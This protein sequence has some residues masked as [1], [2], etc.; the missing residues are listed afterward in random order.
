MLEE[1][2]IGFMVAGGIG[3]SGMQYKLYKDIVYERAQIRTLMSSHDARLASIESDLM[4]IKANMVGW[5]VLKRLELMLA[6]MSAADAKD[7]LSRALGAELAGR[8]AHRETE[9]RK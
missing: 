1:I 8:D 7:G 6:S 9:R 4:F 2:F 3:I 5:D